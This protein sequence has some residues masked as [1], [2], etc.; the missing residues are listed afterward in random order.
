[1][2]NPTYSNLTEAIEANRSIDW[3]RLDRKTA[4]LAHTAMGTL[5]IRLELE[6]DLDG[7]LPHPVDTPQAW[8]EE[9][10]ELEA[11]IESAWLGNGG[12][13]LYIQGEVPL[14]P[15]TESEQG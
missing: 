6:E 10:S 11:V 1:M 12:W 13:T 2:S 8:H 4:R 14:V 5:T 9:G 15:D 3:S 7:N